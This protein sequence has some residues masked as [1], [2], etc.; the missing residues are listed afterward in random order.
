[1]TTQTEPIV[2]APLYP[3]YSHL[4]HCVR[5]WDGEEVKTIRDMINGISD[6]TGTP[7]NPVDWSKPDEWIVERLNGENARLATK[8]W[9]GSGKDVNPRHVYGCYLFINRMDLLE[10]STGIYAIHDRAER[11][12]DED[13]T[14][15]QELDAHEG[16]PRVLSI[17]ATRP[18]AKF[19]DL[20][21]DWSDY[22]LAVSKFKKTSVFRDTLR[23]RLLNLL[24]RRLV[25]RSGSRYSIT[26]EGLSYLESFPEDRT[27]KTI[28]SETAE[29]GAAIRAFNQQKIVE[30]KDRLMGLEP[31]AFEHF[32]KELLEAMDYENVEVTKQS[33]DRGVDVVANYQFGITEI[34]EVVQVKRT[35]TTIGRKIIDQLRGALP[36]HKAIRGTLITLGKFA[37]GVEND[38]LVPPPITLID[39][40][41]LLE[42]VEKHEVGVRKKLAHLLEIDETFFAKQ[43]EDEQEG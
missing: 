38:A 30:L 20:I 41:R 43:S 22:L 5:A 14:L 7:Q 3:L 6:Q 32:V 36:Y 40:E 8:I 9:E 33:G 17:L 15:I 24:E 31:Y 13:P 34:T 39:G 11:F 23:R 2:R 12:L 25:D 26:N 29:V 4:R 28:A 1:M 19:A 42:L 37:R 27:G 10:K 16:L 35:E 18:Q 21:D